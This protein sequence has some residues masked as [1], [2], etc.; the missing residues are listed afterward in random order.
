MARQASQVENLI[1]QGINVLILAPVDSIAA[2]PLVEKA[3]KAGIKVIAY[4]RFIYAPDLDL[5][6]AFNNI[7]IGEL[8][9]QF[10]IR[11]VP[12]GNYII[13]SGEG[14]PAIPRL[15]FLDRQAR[16]IL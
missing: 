16:G 14:L 11:S 12:K 5:Y 13:M 8:Q 9:G 15:H 6:I 3:H 4:D 7:R 10:L 2:A 1:S